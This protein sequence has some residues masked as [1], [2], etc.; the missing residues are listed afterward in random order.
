MGM[1]FGGDPYAA[2]VQALMQRRQ[3]AEQRQPMQQMPQ[4]GGT[5]Q[6]QPANFSAMGGGGQSPMASALGGLPSAS[7]MAD[8]LK[9][10]QGGGNGKTE[11]AM[12]PDGNKVPVVNAIQPVGEAASSPSMWSRFSSMFGG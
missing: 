6:M 11:W 2:L 3:A 8:M 5:M 7:S 9:R 10:M 4:M 1:S 12:A